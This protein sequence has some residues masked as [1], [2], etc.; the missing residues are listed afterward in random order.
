MSL[1]WQLSRQ[2]PEGT[3]RVG[4][5]I[6]PET[7]PYRQIGDRFDDLFPAEDTFAGLY[8]TGGRGAIPPLLMSLVTV[9]QMWE[10][11][12]DRAAAEWVVSRIDWKYA[13]HLPLGYAGF[14]FTDLYAFRQRLLEHEQERYVF[15][16][17]LGKLKALGV[18]RKRGKMRSDSTHILGVVQRLSQFELVAESLR[19]AVRAV[20]VADATWAERTLPA[21]WRET[22]SHR[23]SEYGLSESQ[24]MEQLVQVGQDAHWFLAQVD[25]SASASVRE[26][27]AIAVL[28]RVLTQQFPAGPAQPPASPRPTGRDVIESPHEPEA[29]YGTKRGQSWLGYKVQVTETCDSDQPH[30]ITDLEPTGALDNDSPEL[31]AIQDRLAEQDLTPQEQ[32]VDQGYMSGEH[33]VTSAAQGIDLVGIPLD[34]TQGPQGFRQSDFVIDE[35]A[36]RATCPAGQTS[37][38]WSE[39]PTQDGRAPAIQ[40]R[41]DGQ[42][43]Q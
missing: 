12:P 29:R 36:Q 37:R 19:V 34:D 7:N 25:Q 14:H 18:L 30:L 20:V 42:R 27:S 16:Q 22:Y 13:L 41:F 28:R 3:A 9:F 31:P 1:Q 2:V 26:L 15:E 8:D 39:R 6:L 17:C 43:C 10:N 24:V 21:T 32:Y 38:V 11:V 23:R 4:Q 35:V 5:A 33:L 40:V